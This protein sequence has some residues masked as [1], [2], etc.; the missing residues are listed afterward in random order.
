VLAQFLGL[1]PFLGVTKAVKNAAGMGLAVTFV[2]VL[3][4]VVTWPLQILVL[5]VLGIGFFFFFL[6]ILV[7]GSL[8]QFVEIVLKKYI[9]PL[10]KSLGVFLPLITTNCAIFAVTLINIREE[11]GLIQSLVNALGAGLGFLLVMVIFSGIRE[12]TENAD[13]PKSFKGLPLTLISVAL[14]SL[15]FMGFSG[16]IENL[17][18]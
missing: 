14:L 4:T 2:M 1:C 15:S 6:F 5:N 16:V 13:P 17:F 10:Y 7:I 8:V 18:G 11:Y 12:Y 9:P 3:A